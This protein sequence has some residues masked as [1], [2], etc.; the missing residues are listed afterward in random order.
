MV[1]Y[2]GPSYAGW[3]P[4][5]Y[6]GSFY[7]RHFGFNVS[8]G[9]GF[10]GVS[11]ASWHAYRDWVFCPTGS[12]GNRY[13]YRYHGDHHVLDHHGLSRGSD[14]AFIT[15]D[16]R[17][18]DR[19]QWRDSTAVE[20][21]LSR[22]AH[23]RTGGTAD[24]PDV[25]AVVARSP[26]VSGTLLRELGQGD[27]ERVAVHRRPVGARA[28]VPAPVEPAGR[29]TEIETPSTRV[30]PRRPP[31]LA[32]EG[33]ARPAP[34][35]V[36]RTEPGT[37]SEAG[38]TALRAHRSTGLETPST[39]AVRDRAGERNGVEAGAAVDA[40][41]QSRVLRR[42]TPG[43]ETGRVLDD[44]DR[45]QRRV[46]VLRRDQAPAARSNVAP[47]PRAQRQIHLPRDY[48]A[49]SSEPRA[50]VA[51]PQVERGA[52][53]QPRAQVERSYAPRSVPPARVEP[54]YTPQSPPPS[55]RA[56][57]PSQRAVSPSQRAVPPSQRAV[58]PSQRA[59]PPSQPAARESRAPAA[60]SAPAA[61]PRRMESS[62]PAPATQ[63]PASSSSSRSSAASS[64][65]SSSDGGGGRAHARDGGGDQGSRGGGA[66][67]GRS[68]GRH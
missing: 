38:R 1:W 12:I 33:V 56:V 67:G 3:V 19:G 18:L 7:A 65:S 45:G 27:D 35:R 9:S 42:T 62:R 49:R 17:G 44:S 50:R 64:S 51:R 48:E 25:S 26:E 32:D 52:P 58:P 54:S 30:A 66:G 20:N 5:G 68:S 57:S 39:P 2:W 6:Y 34:A 16:T 14:R 40:A 36:N 21:T 10:Y 43:V 23:R 53:Q 61:V 60:V 37:P 41:P 28:D 31:V 29:T 47:A 46:D 59:A 8:F 13:Q 63:S 55:Q 15:A 4:S 11:H 24:L 22:Q